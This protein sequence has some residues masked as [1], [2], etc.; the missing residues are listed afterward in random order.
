MNETIRKGLRQGIKEFNAE[1]F[2]EAHDTW[3]DAWMDLRGQN[4][5]FLQGLI[6]V[7]IG[8]YH[9]SCENF[10]GADHLLTRAVDKLDKYPDEVEG[11]VLAPLLEQVRMSLRAVRQT[12]AGDTPVS[13]WT[14]PK[15]V[16]RHGAAKVPEA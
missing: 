14:F 15:I 16:V 9:L 11:V 6:Q 1:A 13:F 10:E 5:L 2:F 12:R 8:Y 7:A 4:R 3:E